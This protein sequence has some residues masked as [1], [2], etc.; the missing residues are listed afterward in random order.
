[1]VALEEKQAIA[2]LSA[3]LKRLTSSRLTAARVV[4]TLALALA[5]R[6]HPGGHNTL[7]DLCT[8]YGVDCS[9]RSKDELVIDAAAC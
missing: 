8:R 1:L 9:R 2:F 4:D 5:R 6:K 7:N 3:E